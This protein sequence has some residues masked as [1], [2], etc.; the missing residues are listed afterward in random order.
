[1]AEPVTTWKAAFSPDRKKVT[2]NK[3]LQIWRPPIRGN[4][5][6]MM[7]ETDCHGKVYLINMFPAIHS[8][9]HSSRGVCRY[10]LTEIIKG[11]T[12][13]YFLDNEF[14]FATV[15]IYQPD[16]IFQLPEGS[17]H[18]P[19]Q[20][21]EAEKLRR[22][23]GVGRKVCNKAFMGTV[24]E[25][26]AD[27]AQGEGISIVRAVFQE[28]KGDIFLD[29]PCA[30]E[31]FKA[32]GLSSYEDKGAGLIKN[33][34]IRKGK[35]AGGA[36][37]VNV[38]GAYKKEG[39]LFH[40]MCK[41]IVRG[42]SSVGKEDSMGG[43]SRGIAVNHGTEGPEF[44]FIPPVLY[45]SIKIGSVREVIKG[46]KVHGV[47]AFWG[48]IIDM[49]SG[50]KG[51]T[52]KVNVRAVHGKDT[53]RAFGNSFMEG[54]YKGVEQELES[55]REDL[56]ALLDK[57]RSRRGVQGVIKEKIEELGIKGRTFHGKD[58]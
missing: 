3:L 51:V 44:I 36:V 54:L 22:R 37:A 23:E 28:V 29:E 40:D 11:K 35:P 6:E 16:S 26:E 49:V 10:D 27:E 5:Q 45:E 50:I 42:E 31:G 55:N 14:G 52:E 58:K 20:A 32:A 57:S 2:F 21:I 48:R 56:G 4:L 24:R 8:L 19:A 39:A 34:R 33:V 30:R 13:P 38:F 25:G 1:M 53:E 18:A 12:G 17:L 41:N 7:A 9:R 15:E 46:G 43:R 47:I